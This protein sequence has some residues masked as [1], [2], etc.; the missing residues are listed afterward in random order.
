MP[1]SCTDSSRSNSPR[2][3]APVSSRSATSVAPLDRVTNRYPAERSAR[4]PSGTS[5][6]TPSPA[7]PAST[8][9]T[10]ESRSRFSGTP[11]SAVR[12][13]SA[14]STANDPL[15][16]TAVNANPSRSTPANHT[17]SNS[18]GT[19]TSA[20]RRLNGSMS[21]RVSLTSNT[22][23][24]GRAVIPDQSLSAAKPRS[25][26]TSRAFWPVIPGPIRT[27]ST[28]RRGRG[29]PVIAWGPDVGLRIGLTR[30][31]WR[32]ETRWTG[33][34]VT[35][36]FGDAQAR[37]ERLQPPDRG[38][39]DVGRSG[40]RD[41]RLDRPVRARLEAAAAAELQ[42]GRHHRRGWWVDLPIQVALQH[43]GHPSALR[44]GQPADQ[45]LQ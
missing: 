20:N 44:P 6:W 42:V 2:T 5:G 12:R 24:D 7:K 9:S 39:V 19:P 23:T 33:S 40:G 35:G 26:N 38:L 36:V 31:R 25:V 29:N 16:P 34:V 11:C 10:A 37:G 8:W 18:G 4:S 14:A 17:R 15:A 22:T 41:G 45:H 32:G 27:G 21:D 30:G 43:P 13:P 28:H 1:A 3:P